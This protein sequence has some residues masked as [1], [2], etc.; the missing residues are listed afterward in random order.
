MTISRPRGPIVMVGVGAY[1]L[2]SLSM[3]IAGMLKPALGEVADMIMMLGFFWPY[4]LLLSLH[5]VLPARGPAAVLASAV[6]VMLGLAIVWWFTARAQTRLGHGTW[7]NPRAFL[8][9]PWLWAL[10]L[11]ALQVAAYGLARL[12]GLPVG[13]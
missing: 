3:P 1:V 11:V 9:A 8:W 4:P 12:L 6:I 7:S 13:E 10:P 2:V 5:G